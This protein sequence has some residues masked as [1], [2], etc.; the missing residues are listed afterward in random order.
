MYAYIYNGHINSYCNSINTTITMKNILIEVKEEYIRRSQWRLVN[1]F[2]L[3]GL[4]NA[5]WKCFSVE[6]TKH[7]LFTQYLNDNTKIFGLF[8][9]NSNKFAWRR[10][11][12]TARIK[13]LDTHIVLNN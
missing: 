11:N 12:S 13:W 10:S 5:S 6:V 9:R 4:C 8:K 2:K 1:G 3:H 7:E